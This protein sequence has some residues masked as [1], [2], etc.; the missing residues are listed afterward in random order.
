MAGKAMPL[1]PKTEDEVKVF[2]GSE[3][4]G[5]LV[6]FLSFEWEHGEKA[7]AVQ[8]LGQFYPSEFGQY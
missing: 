5:W 1:L 4:Y 6:V 3:V 7:C 2:D 8:K